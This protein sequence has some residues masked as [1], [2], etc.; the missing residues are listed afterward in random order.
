VAGPA[1]R[2]Y[3]PD[4]LRDPEP[5]LSMDEVGPCPGPCAGAAVYRLYS[6]F[7]SFSAQ[8]VTTL[9]SPAAG[10]QI[11]AIT[12]YMYVRTRM[13][14]RATAVCLVTYLK[15][16]HEIICGRVSVLFWCQCNVLLLQMF[17]H[18]SPALATWTGPLNDSP[19][20][21]QIR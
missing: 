20:A 11:I 10:V 15:T 12:M 16:V 4:Y 9:P 14:L 6:K 5:A 21:T 18:N 3:V 7:S 1:T 17:A 8:S 2:N 19:G 13:S